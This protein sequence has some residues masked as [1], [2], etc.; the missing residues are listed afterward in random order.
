MKTPNVTITELVAGL[1][2]IEAGTRY[3]VPRQ[4]FSAIYIPET[5]PL[6]VEVGDG[7]A[8]SVD[9][10]GLIALPTGA[11]HTLYLGERAPLR[12]APL[13]PPFAQTEIADRVADGSGVVFAGRAPASTNP[14][15]DIV[16]PAI[17]LSREDLRRESQLDLVFRLI[18]DNALRPQ[19][20]RSQIMH[21]LA[22]IVGITLL[23]HVLRRL[24][25]SGV[26]TGD[27]V[28]DPALRR[29]ILAVHDRPEA[30]WSVASLAAEAALS[31]SV[32]AERFK[33]L[34][35]QTP[36]NYLAS[37]RMAKATGLLRASDLSIPEIAFQC[38][39]GSDAAFHNA[40]KR[41]IGASPS[42]Y[43]KAHRT[44]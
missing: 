14:I 19:E 17:L 29:A 24:K 40:F 36:M 39:Y 37:V 20:D 22:E 16:P 35:G 12:R 44:P 13:K 18:R 4:P 10:G 43:R 23:D 15:P 3:A 42:E 27:G 41:M 9:I 25:S 11:A 5:A 8:R 7:P 32:F 21:R 26:N 28:G 6:T 2:E 33:A 30:D 34:L 31:R 1:A 38:G